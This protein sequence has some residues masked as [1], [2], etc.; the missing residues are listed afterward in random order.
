MTSLSSFQIFAYVLFDAGGDVA[1]FRSLV[2]LLANDVLIELDIA[3]ADTLGI[4]VGN[5]RHRLSR[6]VHE[7]VLDEPLTDKLL[8]ELTLGLAFSQLLLI[9]VSIEVTA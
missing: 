1:F 5:L 7:V 4:L 8:R 2:E 3:V 6:L 9:A